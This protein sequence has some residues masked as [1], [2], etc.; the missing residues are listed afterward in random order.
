MAKGKRAAALFE[1]IQAAKEREQLR[2]KGGGFLTPSWWFKGKAAN[3]KPAGTPAQAPPPP[4]KAV[5]RPKNVLPPQPAPIV[6]EPDEPYP[7]EPEYPALSAADSDDTE[8]V[9]AAADAPSGT[10]TPEP[11]P[12]PVHHDFVDNEEPSLEDRTPEAPQ[13]PSQPAAPARPQRRP[14]I[15]TPVNVG[16]DKNR[17]QVVLRLSFT[18]AAISTFGLIVVIA[19]AVLIG[20]SLSKGPAPAGAASIADVKNG[21]AN[22][23][24][25]TVFQ[26]KGGSDDAPIPVAPPHKL[27]QPVPNGGS[28]A[29]SGAN[30]KQPESPK[31]ST[32]SGTSAK[33]AVAGSTTGK[34]IIGKQYVLI[35]SYADPEDANDAVR[36]LK[37]AGIDATVERIPR[38]TRWPCVV[39]TRGFD[40]TKD[41]REFDDYLKAI[42][43]VS[44]VFAGQSNY[45]RFDPQVLGWK[46]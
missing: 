14:L 24:V 29:K 42:R 10:F 38:F 13:Q 11:A 46:E 44:N 19:L 45:H 32:P 37:S 34:R 8:T 15:R 28:Q 12:P 35:Q 27:V 31:E 7:A 33:Q 26:G 43:D 25:M 23:S 20:K 21:K 4:P 18:S 16:V 36:A 22:P 39:G 3:G 9:V 41:N 1:V 2:A 6:D 40:R 30:N 5:A 17:Q